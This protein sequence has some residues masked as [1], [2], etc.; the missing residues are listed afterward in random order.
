MVEKINKKEIKI[1]HSSDAM[2]AQKAVRALAKEIGFT[3]K[4][5]DE[6]VLVTRELVSNLVKH[7]K[8][9]KII[10][11]P[12][13]NGRKKGIKIESIDEGKG[14]PDA[15]K[16]ITDGYSTLNSLGFGLGAVN[17]IMDEFEIISP[18][19]R[20]GTYVISKKWISRK[21]PH[22]VLLCPFEFGAATRTCP[23]SRVNGDSF[24][25]IRDNRIALVAVIDGLGHG[26]FAYRAAQTARSY[27]EKHYTQPLENIF[28][29]VD[30]VCRSTRGVVMAIARFEWL[31]KKMFFGSIGNIG[32][33]V[34]GSSEP[35]NFVIRRGVIGLNAPDPVITKHDW[36]PSYIMILF[37]DG[38]K[39]HWGWR[40]FSAVAHGSA[41]EIARYLLYKFARGDDDATVLVIKGKK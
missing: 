36:D 33:R 23:G 21:L 3:K 30:R 14:I 15:E 7:A 16:A 25:I 29:G 27:I 19:G 22:S 13:F 35:M 2:S 38:V 12:L 1:F 8:R 32:V 24:V 37:S 4:E 10:F 20:K 41:T 31:N 39:T 9:G 26:R 11:T 40:D 17:R 34:F 5:I 18:Y 6:L 28:R